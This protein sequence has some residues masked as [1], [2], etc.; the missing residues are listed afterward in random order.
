[1]NYFRWQ[2]EAGRVWLKSKSAEWVTARR[3]STMGVWIGEGGEMIEGDD[4]YRIGGKKERKEEEVKK[5]DERGG[6]RDEAASE[7]EK[8]T[9]RK[10][11]ARLSWSPASRLCGP[12][13]PAWRKQAR[14]GKGTHTHTEIHTQTYTI[15]PKGETFIEHKNTLYTHLYDKV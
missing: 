7:G 3:P 6:V 5:R 1:M 14:Q 11:G 8:E 10:G 13:V 12:C 4:K 15:I 2:S 9:E